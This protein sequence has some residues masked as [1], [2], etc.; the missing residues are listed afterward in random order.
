MTRL[1]KW[2]IKYYPNPYAAPEN[3]PIRLEG[4]VYGHPRKE[5]GKEV[6]TSPIEKIDHDLRQVTTRTGTVYQL[7]K[8]EEGYR[9]YVL[10]ECPKYIKLLGP[11][12]END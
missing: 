4:V 2:A 8:P 3:Q 6:V 11:T 1:E 10:K 12:V 7:G 9:Q 5:D